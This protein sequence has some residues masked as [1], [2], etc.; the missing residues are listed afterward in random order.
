MIVALDSKELVYSGRIDMTNPE[1]PELIFPASSLNFRFYGRKAVLFVKNR[2]ACWDNYLGAIVDGVQKCWKLNDSGV[3]EVV[4][5]EEEDDREHEVL[6]FKRQDSCHEMV[7]HKLLLSTGSRLLKALPKPERRIEV[8]GD[9]VSAGEVSEA[10]EYV[11]KED[12]EH[13]AGKRHRLGGTASIS[14][15]GIH[16]G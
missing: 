11:G 10:V 13:P 4:L 5:L 9:S 15:Y 16:V 6:V 2:K 14:R 3:T 7:L 1:E 8:Y 12:P